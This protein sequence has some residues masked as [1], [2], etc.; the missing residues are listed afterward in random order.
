MGVSTTF[1]SNNY[2]GDRQ[3]EGLRKREPWPLTLGNIK[4]QNHSTLY[5]MFPAN[6]SASANQWLWYKR[7]AFVILFNFHI[8]A[9]SGHDAHFPLFYFSSELYS[10]TSDLSLLFC[11]FTSFSFSVRLILQ[12]EFIYYLSII[13]C[14]F[15]CFFVYILDLF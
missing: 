15:N 11:D 8:K 2:S 9:T 6:F 14:V 7:N 1:L 10:F 4:Y 13:I 12:L 5:S 3:F